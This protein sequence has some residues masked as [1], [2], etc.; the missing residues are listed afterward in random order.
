MRK[1]YHKNQLT[2]TKLEECK[3][4]NIFRTLHSISL[5]RLQRSRKIKKKL[6]NGKKCVVNSIL[7]HVMPRLPPANILL[8]QMHRQSIF[9]P[10]QRQKNHF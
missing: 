4:T 8:T 2:G 5:T 10:N 7:E 9:R 6:Q 1:N 3:L